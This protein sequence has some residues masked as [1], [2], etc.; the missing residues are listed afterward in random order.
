MLAVFVRNRVTN[1][2]IRGPLGQ[3]GSRVETTQRRK[4]IDGTSTCY[5]LLGAVG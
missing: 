4:A 2:D 5:R 3:K 1:E